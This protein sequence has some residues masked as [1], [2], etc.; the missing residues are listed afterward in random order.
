MLG[1]TTLET[2]RLRGDLI[3]TFKIVKGFS[4]LEAEEFFS[5]NDSVCT[6]GHDLKLHKG[7]FRMDVGKF[8]FGNRIVDKWNALPQ[9][10][11]DS[12]NVNV[13]KN[14]IACHLRNKRG[15]I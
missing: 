11:I 9:D 15:F 10:A 7:R 12:A 3:E 1:L 13:F 6:R 14:R 8:S 2:R 4:N 5:F